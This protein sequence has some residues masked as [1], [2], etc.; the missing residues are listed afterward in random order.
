MHT[1]PQPFTLTNHASGD[2]VIDVTATPKPTDPMVLDVTVS[3]PNEPGCAIFDR[4]TNPGALIRKNGRWH[5]VVYRKPD[6]SGSVRDVGPGRGNRSAA[7]E[8]LF[9]LWYATF[10]PGQG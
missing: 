7:V 3:N 10:S 9:D 5:P 6:G 1:T 8:A 2:F 4:Y